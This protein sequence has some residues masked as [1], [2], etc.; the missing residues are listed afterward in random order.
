MLFAR[1]VLRPFDDNSPKHKT[2]KNRLQLRDVKKYLIII[3][4]THPNAREHKCDLVK[5]RQQANSDC[6]S[7]SDIFNDSFQWLSIN[8]VHKLLGILDTPLNVTYMFLK[9]IIGYHCDTINL[10]FSSNKI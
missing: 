10:R 3:T 5:V 8:F 9:E 6:G 2:S 7:I 1:A 4:V